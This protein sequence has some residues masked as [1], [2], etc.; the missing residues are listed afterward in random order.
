MPVLRGRAL[1]G[2]AVS[3]EVRLLIA[4]AGMIHRTLPGLSPA[5]VDAARDTLIE[6]AR[7]VARRGFDAA[8]PRLAPAL[9]HAAKE[10]ALRRLTDPGLSPGT[11]AR[12]LNVSLRTLQRRAFGAEERQVAAWIRDQRL[13]EARAAL[14]TG[15][16]TVS[17]I[18]ARWQ[19]ADA[20]HVA[21][22]FEQRYGHRPAAARPDALPITP[23]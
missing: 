19:F 16:W 10:L 9:A 2:P 11:L 12:E 14:A 23:R 3:A 7:A 15:R 1:T 21:R 5:G 13:E 6:L 22:A 4:H 18:A 20:S 8:E 17:E